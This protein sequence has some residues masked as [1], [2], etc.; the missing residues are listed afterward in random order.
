MSISAKDIPFVPGTVF[1]DPRKQTFH[2]SHILDKTIASTNVNDEKAINNPIGTTA[3]PMC[4]RG[5][6]Q[7]DPTRITH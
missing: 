5:T 1:V 6:L 4:N 3:T 7:L 2:K